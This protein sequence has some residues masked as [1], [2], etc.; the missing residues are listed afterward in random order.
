MDSSHNRSADCL[1][2][3][4]PITSCS[5]LATISAEKGALVVFEPSAK[6]DAKL[7]SEALKVAHVVKYANQRMPA[8]YGVN[9]SDSTVQLE[10]Q[11]LGS[12]GLRFRSRLSKVKMGGWTHL[13]AL[14]PP[15][16]AD[17]CGAG[18]WCT[19][20]LISKIGVNGLM[21]F[22]E[23]SESDFCNA[24]KQGQ[25]FGAWT[26]GFE[27]ARGGMYHVDKKQF[28]KLTNLILKGK[29]IKRCKIGLTRNFSIQNSIYCP[30]CSG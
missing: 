20:G 29:P 3:G 18:D 21:G 17:T 25:A 15:V 23:L 22:K 2:H 19:A 16:L 11:T 27:G 26:C 12:D 24:L 28:T 4:P 5:T 7:L 13:P 8:L 14:T 1:F 10:I 9:D 30:A 6:S